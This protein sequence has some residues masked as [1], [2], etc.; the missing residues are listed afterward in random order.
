MIG[1][2]GFDLLNAVVA[3]LDTALDV[4]VYDGPVV[5]GDADA[6]Y[7]IVGGTELADEDTDESAF[8]SDGEWRTVPIQAGSR[9]EDITIPCCVVAWSGS[10]DYSTLRGQI[11]THLDTI[12]TALLTVTPVLAGL[13]YI[14][15]TNL[16]LRQ[17][18]DGDGLE[19]RLTFD[20]DARFL[21]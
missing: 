16:S 6:N 5:T 11:N 13:T 1:T 2:K 15:L 20:L 17:I 19:C 10:G 14:N 12:A 21:I 8:T 4:D 18:P 9:G 3:A 7:V